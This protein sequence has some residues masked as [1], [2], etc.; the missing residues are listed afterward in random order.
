VDDKWKNGCTVFL[1]IRAREDVC[2]RLTIAPVAFIPERFLRDSFVGFRDQLQMPIVVRLADLSADRDLL[3]DGLKNWLSPQADERRFDWLYLSNP[4]GRARTWLAVDSVSGGLVGALSAFP[5]RFFRD[6]R[7]VQGCV[8]GDFFVD[9][10]FRSLGPALQLQKV[11]LSATDGKPWELTYDFPSQTM[12]ALYSRLGIEVHSQLVRFAKPLRMDRLLT[13]R[14]LP[15]W[16]TNGIAVIG[17]A[18]LRATA[19]RFYRTPGTTITVQEDPCS[20]EFTEL[21]L[22]VLRPIG[23]DVERSAEYLNW[24]YRNHPYTRHRLYTLRDGTRLAAYAILVQN[25]SD[26]AV[27]DLVGSD[28]TS[29]Q[30]L[31]L[32]IERDLRRLG[33]MVLSVSVSQ[34]HPFEQLLRSLGFRE[35]ESHPIICYTPQGSNG[36][37]VSALANWYFMDG[38]RES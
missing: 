22:G 24:R 11:A 9:P 37:E 16:L 19:R 6:G 36:R 12:T 13:S 29:L 5:R 34:G 26:A 14:V 25:E 4:F 31:L 15:T 10:K 33:T 38:D 30:Q 27:M 18:V 35:R 21:A 1:A 8:W 32:T 20:E 28:E 2:P 17:N 23:I 3:L 7:Q